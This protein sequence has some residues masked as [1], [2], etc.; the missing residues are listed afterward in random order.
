V[1][2]MRA[3]R[4]KAPLSTSQGICGGGLNIGPFF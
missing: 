4:M 3:Y 2:H 1:I